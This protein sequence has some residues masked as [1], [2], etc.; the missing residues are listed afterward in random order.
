MVSNLLF[1]YVTVKTMGKYT[2]F[3]GSGGGEGR[4]ERREVKNSPL[5]WIFSATTESCYPNCQF[6]H[7][8]QKMFC[9]DTG[10]HSV[11]IFIQ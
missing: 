3:G 9:R 4:E 5:L 8:I 11:P 1:C 10:T 2:F 7:K 6:A